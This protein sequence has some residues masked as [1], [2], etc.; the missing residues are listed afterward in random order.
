MYRG[1]CKSSRKKQL[2]QVQWRTDNDCQIFQ[3]TLQSYCN[4][5]YSM[6]L[7]SLD[8]TISRYWTSVS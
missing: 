2:N 1:I 5:C 8:W 6:C 4:R 7:S 3:N